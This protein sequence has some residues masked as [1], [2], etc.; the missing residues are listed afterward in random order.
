MRIKILTC[1]LFFSTIISFSQESKVIDS[2]KK[3]I[4]SAKIIS[5]KFVDL[6]NSLSK[7]YWANNWD[8]VY[9]YTKKAHFRANKI[10][11]QKGKVNSY[12]NYGIYYEKKNNLKI[13]EFYRLKALNLSLKINDNDL[14]GKSYFSLGNLNA[15]LG[16]LNKL[17]NYYSK[18]EEYFEKSKNIEMIAGI[19]NNLG[20]IFQAELK[21]EI[22]LQ[23]FLKALNYYKILKNNTQIS[24]VKS[25]IGVL[26]QS[27]GNN[28]LSKKYF[29]ESVNLKC[30]N[31]LSKQIAYN[32][33][34]NMY[35]KLNKNDSAIYFF[36]KGLE[37]S[38]LTN[39]VYYRDFI[40]LNI[41]NIYLKKK[42]LK[43]AIKLIKSINIESIQRFELKAMYYKNL[44]TYFFYQ[45]DFIS[46]KK[47]SIKAIQVLDNNNIEEILDIYKLYIKIIGKMHNEEEL[48]KLAITNDSLIKLK[49][50]EE[51]SK[52]LIKNETKYRT[53]EKEAQIKTQQLQLAQEKTNKYIAFGGIGLLALTSF[54][55]FMWFRNKQQ[56][57][58]LKSQNTLLTLQQNLNAMQLDNLNKQLDPHEIKNILAN[59]SPEIQR[60]A[61]DAYNKMTKLLNLTR[62][63]L[64]SNSITDSLENQLQQIE[65]YLSLEKTVLSVPLSYT[66]NNTVDT[67][68]P[69]PRL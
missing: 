68:K 31:Y 58:K 15:I 14:I 38:N 67:T 62:A 66:I 11:Y 3:E 7:N 52:N 55:G 47:S 6:N 48:I 19:N 24:L 64:S 57:D 40:K 22:A 49:Y 44:S 33:L 28:I 9:K 27:L 20:S 12:I 26:Y 30:D 32:G 8:S 17:I 5:R 18:A 34:G 10:N 16:K 2:L 4:G 59:I 42:D 61:P 69:I 36:K 51:V 29:I 37:I 65:D 54:G 56:K 60:N 50:N 23:N 13:S 35:D 53:A 45:N 25:N 46:A 63:S 39:D 21:Y 1:L 43:N 41:S